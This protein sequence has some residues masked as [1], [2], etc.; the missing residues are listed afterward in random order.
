MLGFPYLIAKSITIFS[1]ENKLEIFQLVFEYNKEGD[2]FLS[3]I[4]ISL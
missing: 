3:F 1:F 2:I 4:Q